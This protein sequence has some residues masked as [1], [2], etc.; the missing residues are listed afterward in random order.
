MSNIER[1][2]SRYEL[3]LVDA[4][5][6][7]I[8]GVRSPTAQAADFLPIIMGVAPAGFI[9]ESP[10]DGVTAFAGGGQ[11]NATQLTGQTARITTVANIGD[12]VKLPISQAGLEMLVINHGGKSMQ[13]FGSG[14][15]TVDDVVYTTGV[16]QMT[17]SMTIYSCATAGAWYSNGVGTGYSGSLQT[18]S[19]SDA[20]SA[21]SVGTQAGATPITTSIA[22]FTTVAG[23]G[24][25]SVLPTAAAGLE[26]IVINAGVNGMAVFPAGTDKINT[27]AAAASF[28]LPPGGVVNFNATT[29]GQ[30]HTAFTNPTAALPFSLYQTTALASGVIPAS[31]MCGAQ[32]SYLLS[33]G[34]TALTT[35]T[36]A[37]LLAAIPNAS[38]GMQWGLRIINTNGGTLTLTM[39]ASVTS[40]G[41]MT[42]ATNTWRDFLLTITSSTTANMVSVG[43]GS[44]S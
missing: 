37:A 11:A 8:V 33:S 5:T 31:L 24:Y 28:S 42:L 38:V 3:W 23:A 13:V 30:W 12:S 39:D 43:T 19:F 29:T 18:F 22:R 26:I 40:T 15:D 21:A 2:F 34:A 7:Q 16:S 10:Q 27:L 17:G 9:I 20:L 25:S 1:P 44:Y 36:A 41:T 6:G 14:T 35:A 4:S 32:D